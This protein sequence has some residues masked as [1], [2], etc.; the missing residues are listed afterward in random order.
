M[1]RANRSTQSLFVPSS[2]SP[3]VSPHSYPPIR[4]LSQ[5]LHSEVHNVPLS[6]KLREIISVA[7]PPFPLPPLTPRQACHTLL[8][9]DRRPKKQARPFAIREKFPSISPKFSQD[10]STVRLSRSLIPCLTNLQ[11]LHVPNPL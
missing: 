3:L 2:S 10:N 5:P 6:L 7:P 4:L 9:A 1:G 8:T 11:I